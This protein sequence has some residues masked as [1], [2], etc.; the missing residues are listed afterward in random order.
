[1]NPY[2]QLKAY[3]RVIGRLETVKKYFLCQCKSGVINE[4]N[5]SADITQ[6][7]INELV[8]KRDFVESRV[9]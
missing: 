3:K 1:M 8:K 7:L 5:Y 2:M 6:D 9:K 4:W